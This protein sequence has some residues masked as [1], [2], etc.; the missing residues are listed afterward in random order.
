MFFR[1]ENVC[2]MVSMISGQIVQCFD[3]NNKNTSASKKFQSYLT[4]EIKKADIPFLRTIKKKVITRE[5]L[6]NDNNAYH[7]PY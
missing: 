1:K 4:A 3:R 7:A 6:Y 5:E 2:A